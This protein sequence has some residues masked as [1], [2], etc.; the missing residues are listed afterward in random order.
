MTSRFLRAKLFFSF[1]LFVLMC[2]GE[3]ITLVSFGEG[4]TRKEA[5]TDA[6]RNA[7]SQSFTTFVSAN[8]SILND[9]IVADE[10]IGVTSGNIK[11]YKELSIEKI[12]E[13]YYSAAL[14]VTVSIG[15]LINF[16]KSHGSSA[17]LAGQTFMMN[18]K[19][20]NLNKQNEEV[21]L[22]HLLSQL[23]MMEDKL[24]DFSIEVKDPFMSHK[25][26]VKN[27]S[28]WTVPVEVTTTTNGNYENF[29]KI[30]NSTLSSLSLSKEER[31]EYKRHNLPYSKL[32][33]NRGKTKITNWPC[34]D[35]VRYEDDTLFLR[36]DHKTL[37]NIMKSVCEI[38]NSSQRAGVI[39]DKGGQKLRNVGAAHTFT[40]QTQRGF[41]VVNMLTGSDIEIE[42]KK[43]KQYD[44]IGQK[45]DADLIT[46]MNVPQQ[47]GFIFPTQTMLLNFSDDQLAKITGF[48]II[49]P[50][51]EKTLIPKQK[52][53]S[54]L[55]KETI[56]KNSSIPFE[57]LNKRLFV[58]MMEDLG[59]PFSISNDIAILK[60]A[61]NQSAYVNLNTGVLS[62]PDISFN[63]KYIGKEKRLGQENATWMLKSGEK[64][65]N[66]AIVGV[67]FTSRFMNIIS[68]T[69]ASYDVFYFEGVKNRSLE[70][71]KK[72][73]K[74]MVPIVDK[75]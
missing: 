74:N 46:I 71:R 43:S 47:S 75:K 22:N 5:E 70:R 69:Q 21:A 51:K 41:N 23:R 14:Q 55:I 37:E 53:Q 72:I 31:A 44:P 13:K 2:Y 32:T 67:S 17:E 12:S 60:L 63:V 65:N 30:L 40:F 29:F 42:R 68:P 16:A 18:V 11:N 61:D 54:G 8:T 26:P 52:E 39:V 45:W 24:F 48:E 7:V 57:R 36:S 19:I 62:L 20:K 35:I 34:D 6:L 73:K 64:N 56:E 3:E 1:F 49:I 10:M 15:D 38:L 25:T 28:V 50:E 27:N 9:E 4:S 59:I 58:E 33:I 66:N